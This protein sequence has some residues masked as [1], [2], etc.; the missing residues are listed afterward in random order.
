MNWDPVDILEA[1]CLDPVELQATLDKQ[2]LREKWSKQDARKRSLGSS[3]TQWLIVEDE[4]P[5]RRFIRKLI[6]GNLERD[7]HKFE[8]ARRCVVAAHILAGVT[9][10][11]YWQRVKRKQLYR[12][13]AR[14]GRALGL[15]PQTVPAA[16]RWIRERAAPWKVKK[17]KTYT[18]GEVSLTIG[19]FT[20][21][22]RSDRRQNQPNIQNL[23]KGGSPWVVK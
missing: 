1:M 18:L 20:F 3:Y 10:P 23:P 8:T 22:S 5:M 14:W 16:Q 21:D 7:A 9:P 4:P 2:A 17:Q 11:P 12:T 15:G 6:L 13:L 19:G